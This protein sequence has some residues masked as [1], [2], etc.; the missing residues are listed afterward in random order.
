MAGTTKMKGIKTVVIPEP[1]KESRRRISAALHGW[2]CAL[3]T[4]IYS[5]FDCGSADNSASEIPPPIS[6]H[7]EEDNVNTIHKSMSGIKQGIQT[8]DD[9]ETQQHSRDN[10]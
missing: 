6:R 10:L 3:L 2:D 1:C 5:G 4:F 8:K 9:M 7:C